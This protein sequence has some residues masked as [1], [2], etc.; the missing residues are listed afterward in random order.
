VGAAHEAP[1]NFDISP[2]DAPFAGTSAGAGPLSSWAP[3]SE[4]SSTPVT[5]AAAPRAIPTSATHASGV[6][7]CE[8]W[9]DRHPRLHP[10]NAGSLAPAFGS[11]E[12]NAAA[13]CSDALPS[14]CARVPRSLCYFVAGGRRTVTFWGVAHHV[15]AVQALYRCVLSLGSPATYIEAVSSPLVLKTTIAL[16]VVSLASEAPNLNASEVIER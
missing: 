13:L 14:S 12:I 2:V 5:I 9:A 11:G 7:L 8:T 1:P 6:G 10:E 16:F 3:P 4:Y 15:L